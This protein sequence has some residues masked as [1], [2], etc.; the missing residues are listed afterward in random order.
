[1]FNKKRVRCLMLPHQLHQ[2]RYIAVSRISS[3]LINIWA[4]DI[5]SEGTKIT[6]SLMVHLNMSEDY[7]NTVSDVGWTQGLSPDTFSGRRFRDRGDTRVY[8]NR[9]NSGDIYDHRKPCP[10]YFV[11]LQNLCTL[12]RKTFRGACSADY[13][14]ILANVTRSISVSRASRY[15][16]NGDIYRLPGWNI[17]K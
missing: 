16:L 14:K 13:R 4:N 2:Q 11:I 17:C 7:V 15:N 9:P 10:L 3:I 8:H 12:L 1:M 5:E 6:K